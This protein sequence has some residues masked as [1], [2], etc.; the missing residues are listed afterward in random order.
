VSSPVTTITLGAAGDIPIL[1]CEV[2]EPRV[3]CRKTRESGEIEVGV[4]VPHLRGES[5]IHRSKSA[6]D[7]IGRNELK[8][9]RGGL[10]SHEEASVST[11]NAEAEQAAGPS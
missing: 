7:K 5:V 8:A 4:K 2:W 10:R 3:K 6:L 9:W 11:F 1:M